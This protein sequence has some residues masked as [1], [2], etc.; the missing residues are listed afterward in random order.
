M[1]YTEAL[2]MVRS[3]GKFEGEAP[4]VAHFWERLLMGEADRDDGTVASF[5]VTPEERLEFPMLRGKR[6]VRVMADD[7]GFVREV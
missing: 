1:R 4:H 6:V 2:R 3:P 5:R 7:W